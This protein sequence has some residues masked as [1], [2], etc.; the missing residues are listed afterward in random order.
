MEPTLPDEV[1]QPGAP[2]GDAQPLPGGDPQA[3]LQAEDPTVCTN[4]G[5]DPA[6]HGEESY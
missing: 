3:L 4:L 6:L 2:G 5:G 1:L